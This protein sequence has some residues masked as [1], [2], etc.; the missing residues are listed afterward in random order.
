MIYPVYRGAVAVAPLPAL[1]RNKTNGM[2]KLAIRQRSSEN[3]IID[4]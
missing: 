3:G 2:Q 1:R 4:M